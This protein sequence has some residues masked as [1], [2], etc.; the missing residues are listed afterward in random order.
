[1]SN[2][3]TGLDSFLSIADNPAMNTSGRT[4][5]QVV[6]QLQAALA[7]VQAT[8]GVTGSDVAGTV[9]KRLADVLAAL[10][11]PAIVSDTEPSDPDEGA[12]WL[13][14][15]GSAPV[16][17]VW[18]DGSPGE[19][20]DVG[21]GGPVDAEDVGYDNTTSGLAAT[22][23]QGA[24]DELAAAPGGGAWDGF[25]RL[26]ET[27]SAAGTSGQNV[28]GMS[29]T[30]DAS[31]LYEFEALALVSSAATTTGVQVGINL[32]SSA[33][34]GAI[35]FLAQSNNTTAVFAFASAAGITTAFVAPTTSPPPTNSTRLVTIKGLIR[36]NTTPNAIE[37]H[38]RA[39]NNSAVINVEA[40][41]VLRWKKIA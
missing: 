3:P 37:L 34:G 16:L 19:W 12:I 20:V 4:A 38:V 39:S 7:A 41:S 24:I 25:V 6:G 11:A 21:D 27:F 36:T 15:S 33:S 17:K 35:N 22:D 10:G 2:F 1:M 5:T 9:E 8:L 26:A 32:N 23:V 30:P 13:D 31:S 18:L 40:D 28:P 29:F 14:T